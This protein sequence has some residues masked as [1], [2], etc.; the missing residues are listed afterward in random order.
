MSCQVISENTKQDIAAMVDMLFPIDKLR[1]LQKEL[2]K[3]QQDLS[4]RQDE[5]PTID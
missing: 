1:I 5:Q 3:I 2:Q 4:D